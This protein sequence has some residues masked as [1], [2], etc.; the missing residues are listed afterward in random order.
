MLIVRRVDSIQYMLNTRGRVLYRA[1][2]DEITALYRF[3]SGGR[4]FYRLR[5]RIL[6]RFLRINPIET[7]IYNKAHYCA[8]NAPFKITESRRIVIICGGG[9]GARDF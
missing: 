6:Y 7:W 4:V 9:V 3:R 8:L 5:C 1:L 2:V